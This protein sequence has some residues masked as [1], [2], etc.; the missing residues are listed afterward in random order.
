MSERKLQWSS[1]GFSKRVMMSG[2]VRLFIVVEGKVLDPAFYDQVLASDPV[3]AAN[4]YE[5]RL[6][7]QIT[8]GGVGSG[9]KQAALALFDEYRT[10]K[11]L[12]QNNNLGDHQ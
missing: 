9:G 11:C 7:Q 5:I 12:R 2:V 10:S 4:G 8:R 3:I 6:V 1:A